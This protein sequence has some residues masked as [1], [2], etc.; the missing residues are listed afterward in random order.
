[1]DVRNAAN[2]AYRTSFAKLAAETRLKRAKNDKIGTTGSGGSTVEDLAQSALGHDLSDERYEA[3]RGIGYTGS[4][5]FT[6]LEAL[7]F[8]GRGPWTRAEVCYALGGTTDQCRPDGPLGGPRRLRL[9][10]LPLR[11]QV[12]RTA[13]R[14][15]LRR[16]GRRH[17]R[18]RRQDH[19][20]SSGNQRRGR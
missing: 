19:P 3:L 4:R 6:W 9:R 15:S 1:M 7:D 20:R 12:L 11:H 10:R 18:T 14:Q 5:H 13:R 17:R 8:A 2:T 16:H